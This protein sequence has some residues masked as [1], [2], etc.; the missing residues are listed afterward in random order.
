MNFA[1]KIEQKLSSIAKPVLTY[2]ENKRSP[3]VSYGQEQE[4]RA[5]EYLFGSVDRF[6]DIGAYDGIKYSNTFLFA[7][8]GARGLCF[9]PVRWTFTKLNRLYW[10]NP[11][12]KCINEGISD[13]ERVLEIRSYGALS[14]IDETKNTRHRELVKFEANAP[15]EKITV[16]SLNYWLSKYPEFGKTDLI[17]LDVEGHELMVLKGIDFSRLQAKCWIVE[18]HHSLSG[19]W[20][21]KDYEEINAILEEAGY[22]ACLK[23]KYNTFWISKAIVDADLIEKVVLEFEGYALV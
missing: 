13:R 3:Q 7:L 19:L 17:S 14:S 9:E 15:V 1:N 2:V 5:I 16:R 18:T 10:L 23:N 12:V 6:I 11:Q 21:H 20:T 8:K 22:T 4:D